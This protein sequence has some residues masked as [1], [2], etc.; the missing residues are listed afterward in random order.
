M[1]SF[2]NLD[3]S[4]GLTAQ[5]ILEHENFEVT[6]PWLNQVSACEYG[7][8]A[9]LNWAE[10]MGFEYT[11]NEYFS[12]FLPVG[13]CIEFLLTEHCKAE[14]AKTRAM[15]RQHIRPFGA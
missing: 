11:P 7:D 13:D 8:E 14:D 15:I 2:F 1:T 5:D 12:D 4:G 10:S 3:P 6:R 9:L